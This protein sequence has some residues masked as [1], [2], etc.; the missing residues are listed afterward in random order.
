MLSQIKNT[1]LTKWDKDQDILPISEFFN[2]K[3]LADNHL[4]PYIHMTENGGFV[5]Q[6]DVASNLLNAANKTLAMNIQPNDV[7]EIVLADKSK[8]DLKKIEFK[9]FDDLIK[10]ATLLKGDRKYIPQKQIKQNF[11]NQFSGSLPR[12]IDDKKIVSLDLEFDEVKDSMIFEIG[13]TISQNGITKNY[14]YI[15]KENND[16]KSKIRLSG[17]FNFGETKFIDN[18][19]IAA[20]LEKHLEKTDYLVGHGVVNDYKILLNNGVDLFDDK[21]M[22]ILD[23]QKMIK[24][25]F[26]ITGEKRQ[27]H[28]LKDSLKMFNIQH[29]NLHNAGNDS[30]YTYRLLEEIFSAI[31]IT[32]NNNLTF[33]Q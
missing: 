8:H 24:T 22:L 5:I 2:L 4:I 9:N 17:A 23:T 15:V 20:I 10:Q 14:H 30:A 26:K 25:Y 27:V 18:N 21:S 3:N 7:R 13:L 32:K 6:S 33:T 29:K 19:Q 11:N 1:Y 28:S 31:R 16:K 12:K